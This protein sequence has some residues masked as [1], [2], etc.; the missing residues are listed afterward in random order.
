QP[1]AARRG[2]PLFYLLCSSPGCPGKMAAD[3]K[4]GKLARTT[5]QTAV[6]ANTRPVIIPAITAQSRVAWRPSL[7]TL[8][9]QHSPFPTGFQSPQL[10]AHG[11]ELVPS[12]LR[13]RHGPAG[14]ALRVA[15][16][17]APQPGSGTRLSRRLQR[18]GAVPGRAIQPLP[19]LRLQAARARFQR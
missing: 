14:G 17:S 15:A 13:P 16:F 2:L 11:S 6:E 7:R 10:E 3:G 18:R 4:A 1:A 5:A 19:S 9:E 8:G 12:H